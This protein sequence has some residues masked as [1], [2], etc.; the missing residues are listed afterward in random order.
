MNEYKE[1]NN[2]KIDIDNY[3]DTKIDNHR[4]KSI[5]KS[6]IRSRKNK[7][8]K[9]AL[10]PI[11]LIFGSIIISVKYPTFAE[12][13]PLL[14]N[15]MYFIQSSIQ[16]GTFENSVTIVNK[17]FTNDGLT[18]LVNKSWYDG[19]QIYIDFT[20]KSDKP[21]KSI[22]Y[23]N[24][25]FDIDYDKI[26]EEK[27]LNLHDRKLIINNEEIDNFS[28]ELPRVKFIDEH[29]LKGRLLIDFIPTNNESS[30]MADIKFSFKLAELNNDNQVVNIFNGNWTLDF[31]VNSNSK[32]FNKIKVNETK[33]NI[34]LKD[35]RVT[36]TSLNLN[37]I[38]KKD[39]PIGYVYVKDNNGNILSSGTGVSNGNS[40][41]GVFYL[42]S[43]GE[44]PDYVTALVY[45]LDE[46]NKEPLAEFKI[47][48]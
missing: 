4:I 45:G 32:L 1:L 19:N 43:I 3:E 46:N 26:S 44:K 13:I 31:S 8:I 25:L 47:K 42:N 48:L 12:K 16:N 10:L 36:Q 33:N 34:Q 2:T 35:I 37:L 28:F 9:V 24:A 18:F 22:E 27:Y 11:A 14:D 38:S 21:F 39:K 7:K 17:S 29:T 15:M 40:Y 41:E 23:K 20:M 5:V 6:K 30:D